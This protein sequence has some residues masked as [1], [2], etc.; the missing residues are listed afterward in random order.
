MLNRLSGKGHLNSNDHHRR[1]TFRDKIAEPGTVN[2]HT[3][4][5]LGHQYTGLP[6]LSSF[7]HSQPSQSILQM[8]VGCTSNHNMCKHSIVSFCFSN[9]PAL[10]TEPTSLLPTLLPLSAAMFLQS[11]PNTLKALAQ[12]TSL[13]CVF[14]S[15]SG[16]SLQRSAQQW[17][18]EVSLSPVTTICSL[19]LNTLWVSLELLP[20]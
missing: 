16:L 14:S 19:H 3:S 9:D 12:A 17:S 4:L 2:P 8:A 6:F 5:P 1:Q 10:P 18:P 20:P 15:P 11:L 7:F 13:P